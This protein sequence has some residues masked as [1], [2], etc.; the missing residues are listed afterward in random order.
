M[1][2]FAWVIAMARARRAFLVMLEP[3]SSDTTIQQ[4]GLPVKLNLGRALQTAN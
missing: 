3:H 1:S 4:N 2:G